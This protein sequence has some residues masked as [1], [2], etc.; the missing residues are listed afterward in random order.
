MQSIC[1]IDELNTW[2]VKEKKY[3]LA[4]I[5]ASGTCAAVF[6]TNK[7]RAPVINL[8]A[9]RIKKRGY[10]SGIIVNSGC[11]NAYT[12]KRG[13]EDAITMATIGADAMG[14]D[15]NEVGV[16]STGVIGRYLDLDRINRQSIEVSQKLCNSEQA[17]MAAANAIGTTDTFQKHALIKR[18]DFTVAGICKGSGMIAPNMG[19]MLAFIYT[20]VDISSSDLQTSLKVATNR[21]FNRV[22]VDGDE[23]T[24]DSVFCT[25]TGSAGKINQKEFETALEQCCVSLAKQIATDGEGA[26]K[27][28]EVRV[29]GTRSESDAE[30]IARTI[31]KSPLVKT[32][33][34]GEDPNW[35][36]I[37]CAAGYSGV[38]FDIN[39][40]SLSIGEGPDETVLVKNGDITADLVKAKKNMVGKK[41]VVTVTLESGSEEAVAWGCDLTEKY[42]EINGRYTT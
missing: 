10:L 23:S 29:K 40:L 28:L 16:A 13:Y 1:A 2:G 7:V 39:E 20:N 36:R 32:A 15:E 31:A 34:Y 17:E 8:M 18:P 21:S 9:E 30:M 26:T 35:G 25:A 12:G 6:T 33:V 38:D 14:I 5:K 4:L 27:L 37:V 22:V 3:G 42:V 24:N 41:V 11:A 19:T